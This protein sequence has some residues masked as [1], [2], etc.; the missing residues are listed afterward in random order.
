MDYICERFICLD[1]ARMFNHHPEL[2]P[3][4]C[5]IYTLIY[6]GI[7]A[8]NSLRFILD[9]ILGYEIIIAIAMSL[10]RSL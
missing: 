1:N 8:L 10:P 4:F 3:V 9:L 6:Q 7:S 2:L 5:Q